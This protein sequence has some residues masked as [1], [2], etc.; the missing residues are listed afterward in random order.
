MS[1]SWCHFTAIEEWLRHR[2]RFKFTFSSKRRITLK[3][4]PFEHL[5]ENFLKHHFS[6]IYLCFYMFLYILKCMNTMCSVCIL[7]LVCLFS[8]LTGSC[9]VSGYHLLQERLSLS[10]C[11]PCVT[12]L[13]EKRDHKE[14][15]EEY[16]RQCGR[17]KGKGEIG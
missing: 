7:F 6:Y 9:V 15:K 11:V 17:R 8:G 14:S 10:L 4:F 16:M 3:H 12:T 5:W 1:L 2:P 13:N